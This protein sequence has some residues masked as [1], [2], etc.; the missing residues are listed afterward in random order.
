MQ[1][2][3]NDVVTGSV[4]L[5]MIQLPLLFLLVAFKYLCSGMTNPYRLI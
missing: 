5:W 2:S 1:A 4:S 3:H